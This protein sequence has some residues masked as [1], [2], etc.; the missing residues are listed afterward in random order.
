[1]EMKV[2]GRIIYVKPLDIPDNLYSRMQNMLNEY[3]SRQTRGKKRK[4]KRSF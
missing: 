1:M 3:T 4:R 2:T